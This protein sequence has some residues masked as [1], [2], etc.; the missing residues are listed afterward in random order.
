MDSDVPS[1]GTKIEERIQIA[2]SA[3]ETLGSDRP[4]GG[5]WFSHESLCSPLLEKRAAFPN[6]FTNNY[7]IV[8]PRLPP[9]AQSSRAAGL[10]HRPIICG[11]TR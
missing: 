11:S 2:S 9:V 4:T 8:W 5:K 3:D 1:F 6:Q 10:A 7:K